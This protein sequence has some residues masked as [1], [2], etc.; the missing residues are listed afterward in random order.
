MKT[1]RQIKKLAENNPEALGQKNVEILNWIEN[2]TLVRKVELAPLSPNKS[3]ATA[4][5]SPGPSLMEKRKLGSIAGYN[6]KS[7][8]DNLVDDDFALNP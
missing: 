8:L 1:E 7:E 3:A 5:A 4:V 2:T 6:T